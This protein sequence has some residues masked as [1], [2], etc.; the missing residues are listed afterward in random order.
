MQ[1]SNLERE[2]QRRVDCRTRLRVTRKVFK[3]SSLT[4]AGSGDA[5]DSHKRVIAVSAVNQPPLVETEQHGPEEPFQR[6]TAALLVRCCEGPDVH[7]IVA[8]G[9]AKDQGCWSKL[10]SSLLAQCH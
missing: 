5:A 10:G 7:R 6:P 3:R 8:H 2:A 9:A 4:K 1:R